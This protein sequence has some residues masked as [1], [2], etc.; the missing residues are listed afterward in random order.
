[1]WLKDMVFSHQETRMNYNMPAC[2]IC[3]P[4]TTQ[5]AKCSKADTSW[6][7]KLSASMSASAPLD[8]HMNTLNN[9]KSALLLQAR[10]WIST[11]QPRKSTANRQAGLHLASF[12]VP[13]A[14][15]VVP[16][17]RYNLGAIGRYCHSQHIVSVPLEHLQHLV[18]QSAN[19]SPE[20]DGTVL[21]CAFHHRSIKHHE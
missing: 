9:Q 2:C 16:T 18:Q 6:L 8:Q 12:H 15:G 1:M 3:V 10:H 11:A 19:Q 17:A 4:A 14:H 7:V 21:Y 20:L 5:P 13:D